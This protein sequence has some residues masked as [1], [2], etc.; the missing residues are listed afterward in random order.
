MV[1]FGYAELR[2]LST[3]PGDWLFQ[4]AGG[5]KNGSWD[6]NGSVAAASRRERVLGPF[7][8]WKCRLR[9]VSELWVTKMLQESTIVRK[10]CIEKT[11]ILDLISVDMDGE[12]YGHVQVAICMS[13][14]C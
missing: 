12:T 5:T 13:Y 14:A 2:V 7:L 11:L 3:V 4:F 8:S 10:K 6:G 9:T 1:M